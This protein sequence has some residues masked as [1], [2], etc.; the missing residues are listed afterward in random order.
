MNMTSSDDEVFN[1]SLEYQSWICRFKCI[2][3]VL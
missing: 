2:S 3:L 1:I